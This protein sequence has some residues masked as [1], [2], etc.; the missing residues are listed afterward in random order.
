MD[1]GVLV[2]REL[3]FHNHVRETARKAGGLAQNFIKSTV[4]RSPEFMLFLW[5]THIRPMIEY[6]SCIWN[7]GYATDVS[8]LERVQRRWTK[9]ITGLENL[10]YSE[11]LKALNLYSIQGRLMRADLIQYWKVLNGKSCIHPDS[12]F[13]QPNLSRTRGHSLKLFYHPVSTDVRKRFFTVR[14]I[15]RWNRLPGEVVCAPDLRTF[16]RLLSE[17]MHSELFMFTGR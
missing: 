2:D 10:C 8:L 4:S 13:T 16:K 7:T 14:C 3:K 6:G 15:Q 5:T 1:L 17:C 9:H 11:R 12:L